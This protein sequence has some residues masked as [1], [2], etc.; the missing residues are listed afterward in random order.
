MSARAKKTVAGTEVAV[1]PDISV[2]PAM[3]RDRAAAQYLGMS[4][5]W[6]RKM[7][8]LDA[9]ARR[10]GRPPTGPTWVVVG[11]TVLYR[12]ADLDAWI[13]AN[14]VERGVVQFSNRG[15]VIKP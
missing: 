6:L 10:E 2:R 7:R 5:S 12:L 3:A 8:L 9:K 4:A 1:V 15:G 14:A 11:A 13:T